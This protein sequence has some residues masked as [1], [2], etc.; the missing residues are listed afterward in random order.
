MND[1]ASIDLGATGIG[2]TASKVLV[3]CLTLAWPTRPTWVAPVGSILSGV[4]CVGLQ[5]L[6][7]GD[8]LDM[9]H[10]ASIVLNGIVAGGLAMGITALGNS[11]QAKRQ[12]AGQ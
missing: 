7:A 3:D 6:A 9:Q 11:A 5:Q 12:E 10:T 4:L 1:G 2:T 8:V